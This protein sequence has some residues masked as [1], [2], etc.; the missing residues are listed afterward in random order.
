MQGGTNEGKLVDR[1]FETASVDVGCAKLTWKVEKVEAEKPSFGER[2]C[3][4]PHDH[5]DVKGS[6]QEYWADV[7]CDL[8]RVMRPELPDRYT[9]VG[10]GVSGGDSDMEYKV[11]WIEGCDMVEE[12]DPR[13]PVEGDTG[14][15]CGS[16][17]KGSYNDC[18][19]PGLRRC[20]ILC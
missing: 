19:F 15:S 9:M 7:V 2:K 11:S 3:H 20:N 13:F 14:I 17:M 6:D 12:Q 4:E 5:P 18:K 8:M 16:I 10:S 1:M